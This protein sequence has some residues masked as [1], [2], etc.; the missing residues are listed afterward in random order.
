MA[1]TREFKIERYHDGKLPPWQIAD[2][3]SHL[4]ATNY[5]QGT[6]FEERERDIAARRTPEALRELLKQKQR[7]LFV[8]R[9]SRKQVIGLLECAEVPAPEQHLTYA[10]LIWIMVS[11]AERETRIEGKKISTHLHDAFEEEARRIKARTK[12]RVVQLLSVY[13]SNP[14]VHTY[15]RWGYEHYGDV[16]DRPS[17]VFMVKEELT[18]ERMLERAERMVDSAFIEH[19]PRLKN[20][21]GIGNTEDLVK[22]MLNWFVRFCQERIGDVPAQFVRDQYPLRTAFLAE[23]RNALDAAIRTLQESTAPP[24]HELRRHPKS[25][26]ETKHRSTRSRRRERERREERR[27]NT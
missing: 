23:V 11:R 3:V 22:E 1:E 6:S 24:P 15:E 20:I 27:D 17:K 18:L 16:L 25:P 26:R 21:L 2:A 19:G 7:V 4:F 5:P 14:A 8:A 10:Q 13:K 12:G 9:K